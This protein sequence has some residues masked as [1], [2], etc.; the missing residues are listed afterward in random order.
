MKHHKKRMR[1]LCQ[2]KMLESEVREFHNICQLA[3][4]TV[5]EYDLLSACITSMKSMKAAKTE[6]DNTIGMMDACKL[7][8]EEGLSV[9][10]TLWDF[11]GLVL[12][13]VAVDSA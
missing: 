13:G 6:I 8:Q 2:V 5:A 11:C 12:Q 10:P 4:L 7:Q 9:N 1:E 3:R